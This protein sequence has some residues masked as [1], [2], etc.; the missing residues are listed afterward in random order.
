MLWI[1]LS[2]TKVPVDLSV[3]LFVT[4]LKAQSENPVLGPP[5]P[6]VMNF[7]WGIWSYYTAVK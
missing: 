2:P 5:N 1:V 7:L 4:N 3:D 6:M